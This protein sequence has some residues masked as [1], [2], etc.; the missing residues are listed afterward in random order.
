M[1]RRSV[2]TICG[3]H[4]IG[5][6]SQL[7]PKH[8]SAENELASHS[9]GCEVGIWTLWNPYN[10]YTSIGPQFNAGTA[11]W[12]YHLGSSLLNLAS[13]PGIVAPDATIFCTHPDGHLV[14]GGIR[15]L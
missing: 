7:L 9:V 2:G 5:I 11:L 14:L 15:H 6:Q 1:V 13:M 12:W 3:N 4:A 8:L 10:S